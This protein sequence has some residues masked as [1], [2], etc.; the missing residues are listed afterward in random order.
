[1]RIEPGARTQ[2]L[3]C[4]LAIITA[5]WFGNGGCEN[6][7]RRPEQSNYI[8]NL[9]WL[10]LLDLEAESVRIEPAPENINK[11]ST[12]YHY[13]YLIWKRSLWESKPAPWTQL[14]HCQL[15]SVTTSRFGSGVCEYRTRAPY[16]VFTLS[17]CYHYGFLI[18]KRSLWERTRSPYRV[19]T[20]STCYHYGSLI[21]KRSLWQSNSAPWTQKLHCQLALVTAS[22]CGRGVCDN[23]TRAPNTIIT[24]STCYDYGFF[25]WERSLWE[26]NSAPRTQ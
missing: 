7:T 5:S 17:T 13:G 18:W 3:H 8:A 4:Q 16:T 10:R 9:L 6:W 26:S 11:I 12:C 20:F 22:R 15:A 24:L 2:I 14:L 25:I 23:R 1:V 21:W 19:I